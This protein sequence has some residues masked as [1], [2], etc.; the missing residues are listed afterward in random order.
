MATAINILESWLDQA[1]RRHRKYE[2]PLVTLSYAQS[3]DGSITAQRGR[4]LGLS[5]SRSN[6]LTH[7][8][9]AAHDAILVGIGTVL[10]DNPLLTVR[11]VEGKHPQP[12]ILDSHL[13]TPVQ[14]RLVQQ[15]PAPVWI[16]TTE[17]VKSQQIQN[18]QASGARLFFMA[19]DVQGRVSL[20]E[21]LITLAE[22]GIRSLMIEG[23]AQV[24]AS[25][26]KERLVDQVILTLAPVFLGGVQA[27]NAGGPLA[28]VRDNLP[29][30]HESGSQ[31]LD[32]DLILWGKLRYP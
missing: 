12:V 22:N 17:Q 3:L 20:P 31:W 26:L 23:G 28:E 32:G 29:T 2:R 8:I 5:N 9:R 18:L 14:A 4:P 25:F 27:V 15:H 21:L 19:G 30:L 6:R 16:A 13:R 24:I 1:S 10:A 11:L 7:E